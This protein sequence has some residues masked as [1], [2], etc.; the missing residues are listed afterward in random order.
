M[1]FL[2]FARLDEGAVSPC[3]PSVF[4]FCCLFEE[5]FQIN[6]CAE[7]NRLNHLRESVR[8]EVEV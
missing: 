2:P 6:E 8:L 7:N 4:F 1:Y 3:P 5:T